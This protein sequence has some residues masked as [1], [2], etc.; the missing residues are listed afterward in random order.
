MSFKINEP[1]KTVAFSSGGGD[2]ES[3]TTASK[4]LSIDRLGSKRDADGF[5]HGYRIEN[6]PKVNFCFLESGWRTE[7]CLMF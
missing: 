5:G 1:E 4:Y 2:V 3:Y 7:A 6:F